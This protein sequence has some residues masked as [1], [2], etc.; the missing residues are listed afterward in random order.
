MSSSAP[1]TIGVDVG[2]T[3]LRIG[4]FQQGKLLHQQRVHAD[5][6][7]LCQ[8]SA[9]EHAEQDI[10]KILQAELHSVLQQYPAGQSIGI[11]FPGFIHPQRKV[12][13][14][15]PNLPGLSDVDIAGPLS[16]ALKRPVL[17][18]NDALCAAL[19][20]YHLAGLTASDSLIYIGLGTGIG[21]GF[22][23]AGKPY[24]GDHGV[25]MEFGHLIVEA[26][27]RLCGCGNHGCVE[28]Y[29]SAGGVSKNFAQLSA[30]AEQLETQQIAQLAQAGNAQAQQAFVM[31]GQYL[32]RAIAHACK[33]LDVQHIILGGGVMQAH[34][35]M[36]PAL[37]AQ[38]EQDLIPVLRGVLQIR[39]AQSDDIAGMLGAAMLAQA[40]A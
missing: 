8:Q 20:E 14:L 11:G 38:L 26:G 29:A 9:A 40:I 13:T 36:M 16:I 22:I 32:G 10:L 3:N 23:H 17:L 5:F 19:A 2:G 39:L 37:K 33:L 31:A 6:A 28:Q 7:G 34:D 18:E 27:G 30:S 25:A 1:L 12:I 35:L 15:S 4:V 24:G 21:G